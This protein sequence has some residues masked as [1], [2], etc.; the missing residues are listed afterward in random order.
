M[1]SKGLYIIACFAALALFSCDELANLEKPEQPEQPAEPEYQGMSYERNLVLGGYS[2]DTTLTVREFKSAIKS[3]AEDADWL[4]VTSNSDTVSNTYQI[5]VVCSENFTDQ[6][7]SASVVIVCQN[8]DTLNLNISQRVYVGKSYVSE[9][10]FD[11]YEQDTILAINEFTYVIDEIRN[12]ADWLE[13][14]SVTDTI[15]NLTQL[16]ILCS[17]NATTTI[18]STDVVLISHR[19]TLTLKVSQ[20]VLKG[21][22]DPHDNVTDQPALT[23]IR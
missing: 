12:D 2:Q 23:P 6:V 16:E 3:I 14:Q 18:R 21:F 15:S 8:R 4:Q 11:G 1:R 9:L 17:K 13:A 20:N 5:R 7:R 10:S 19:D 22:E